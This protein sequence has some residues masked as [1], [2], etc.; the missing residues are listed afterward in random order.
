L[1]LSS[2]AGLTDAADGYLARRLGWAS[3]LGAYLDPIADKFLLTSLYVCFGIAEIVPNAVVALVVGRDI[4]I[5]LLTAGGILFT[6][7]RDYPPTIWGKISTVIQITAAVIFLSAC[8]Y[9]TSLAV[10]LS[11]LAVPAVVLA[12]AWSGVHYVWRAVAWSRKAG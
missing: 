9:P 4:L 2:I 12:T 11:R 8:A 3:R 6:A 7:R 1:W 5:L 10:T